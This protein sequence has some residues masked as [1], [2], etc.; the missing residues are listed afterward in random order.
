MNRKI[1]LCKKFTTSKIY[2][3]LL[4]INTIGELMSNCVLIFT[5][6]KTLNKGKR[7]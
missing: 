5:L 4:R 2:Q 1:Q 7:T 6:I 3:A